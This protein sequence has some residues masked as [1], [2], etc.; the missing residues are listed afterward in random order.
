[1]RFFLLLMMLIVSSYAYSGPR[2]RCSLK[3]DPGLCRAAFTKYFFDPASNSCKAFMWGGC[4]G[5]VPFDRYKECASACFG[6]SSFKNTRLKEKLAES[7]KKWQKLKRQWGNDYAYDVGFQSWVG[8]GHRARITIKNDVPVK[9]E[10]WT[11]KKN[12]PE[13]FRWVENHTSLHTHR[14]GA[15]AVTVE[16]LYKRCRKDT[17]QQSSKE[18]RIDLTFDS[19]GLLKTC[20][21][22]HRMCADDCSQGIRID[23]LRFGS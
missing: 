17:L 20:L 11:F 6:K 2:E 21:Y 1:M 13:K 23:S 15:N 9:R 16:A 12:S 22:S 14:D 5:T 10:Y 8:F 7:L 3:P 19:S 4:G 18:N